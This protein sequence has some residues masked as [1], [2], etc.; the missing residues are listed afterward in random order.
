MAVVEYADANTR[1]Q[2]LGRPINRV[3]GAKHD[4]AKF[5]SSEV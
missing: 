4:G 1:D 5:M 2:V 3:K